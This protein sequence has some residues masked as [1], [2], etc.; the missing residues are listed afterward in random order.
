MEIL[1]I[2]GMVWFIC[3]LMT[4]PKLVKLFRERSGL[5][6][7]LLVLFTI[8]VLFVLGPYSLG[9]LKHGEHDYW[10]D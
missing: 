2:L 4:I 10:P 3:S 1:I 9:T 6:P 8:V 7:L 5:E